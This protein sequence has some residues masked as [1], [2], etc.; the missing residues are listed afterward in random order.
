MKKFWSQSLEIKSIIVSSLVTLLGFGGTAFL[1]WLQHYEIPLGVLIGG[2]VVITSWLLLY[3]IKKKGS[4]HVKLEIA[5]IYVRLGVVVGLTAL[6]V[7]LELALSIVIVSP[8]ALVVAYL[9]ISLLTLLAYIQKGEE[10][11]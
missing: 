6:F 8:I 5:L 3:L 11:V 4:H 7:V 9:V 2:L 1:F 10:N